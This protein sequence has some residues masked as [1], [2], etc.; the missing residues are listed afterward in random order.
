MADIESRL[1][2]AET[3]INSVEKNIEDIKREVHEIN[4]YLKNELIEKAK[5]AKDTIK[6]IKRSRRDKLTLWGA[7]SFAIVSFA[8]SILHFFL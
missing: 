8:V 1:A 3:K 2:I 6:D 5:D 4:S 7:L